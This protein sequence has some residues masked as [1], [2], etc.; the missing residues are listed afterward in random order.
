[1]RLQFL[2]AQSKAVQESGQ[3]H[4]NQEHSQ[5][6]NDESDDLKLPLED[7]VAE[8]FDETDRSAAKLSDVKGMSLVENATDTVNTPVT[9]GES[10]GF[11]LVCGYVEQLM[12][13]GDV[14]SKVGTETAGKRPL[15]L[16]PSQICFSD[17][18]MG[19][20][21]MEYLERYSKGSSEFLFILTMTLKAEIMS[22]TLIA[23]VLRDQK[24]QSL[25][26]TAADML[27]FLKDAKLII[28]EI[29]VPIVSD[30]MKQIYHCAIFVREYGGGGFFSKSRSK[31]DIFYF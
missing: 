26:G 2:E 23:Q 28:D 19:K 17:T 14:V 27:A 31:K 25:W 13:I 1:M 16:M 30:M 11:A 9:I 29:L 20:P 18:P 8:L 12:K 22:Q 3:S 4:E 10:D 5:P 24:V 15:S 6:S 21:R 7:Q